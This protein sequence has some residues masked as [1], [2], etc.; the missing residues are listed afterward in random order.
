MKSFEIRDIPVA[1]KADNPL[2]PDQFPDT[3]HPARQTI[4]VGHEQAEAE[5][6]EAVQQKRLHHAWLIGGVEGIGKATFAYRV[7]R[8]ILDNAPEELA[9]A[10]SLDVPQET[11]TFR[12]IE[13]FSHPNLCVLRR[14]LSADN[15]ISSVISVDAVRKALR[16][17]TTTSVAGRYRV[18]IIDTAE[19]LNNSSANALLKL[20]EE[21]PP[22][23]LFLIVS[24]APQRLLPTIRSRCRKLHLRPLHDDHIRRII[25]HFEGKWKSVS[26]ENLDWA[27][28][29]GEGSVRRTLKMLNEEN[30][31]LMQKVEKMLSQLPSK[32]DRIVVSLAE[33]LS[34]KGN[35]EIFSLFI[36]YL[37]NWSSH[38]IAQNIG[39]TKQSSS[40]ENI[41]VRFVPLIQSVEQIIKSIR[42]AEIYN[43]DK[44][45]LVIRLFDDLS[46]SLK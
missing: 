8:F 5:I 26:Q 10:V 37:Q 31:I 28:H 38:L 29:S 46:R 4:L 16:L 21:P 23:S 17:F 41:A 27:I 30:M 14:T 7:A 42:E 20:I 3:P 43:L 2:E 9:H 18:C 40:S 12:Q 45:P 24:H 39:E 15:K 35:E 11:K 34:Q 1:T 25:T 44:R 19:D 6:L 22:N 33:T 36:D 13:A 32:N